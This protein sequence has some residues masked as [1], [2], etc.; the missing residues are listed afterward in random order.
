V[1]R[2][3]AS[4]LYGQLTAAGYSPAAAVVQTA[5]ALAETGGDP[6][7]R[8]G[9]GNASA[10]GA[11]LIRV[12]PAATGTGSARDVA[13]LAGD[14]AAQAAAAY[15]V[16]QA[17][18]NFTPWAAY[19]DGSFQ[20]YLG[21]ASAAAGPT[22]AKAAGIGPDWLPWNWDDAV[23]KRLTG[24]R[25]LMLVCLMAAAGLGLV[26]L[27]LGKMAAPVQV[28]MWKQGLRVAKKVL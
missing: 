16:S 7:A 4:Q 25:D 17:G 22:G 23:G 8:L 26:G 2:L 6:D 3:S 14:P 9:D 21:Q 24:A 11:Y 18:T 5:I 12:D 1:A 13:L 19:R 10:V 15:Q 20:Q 28:G 27:G